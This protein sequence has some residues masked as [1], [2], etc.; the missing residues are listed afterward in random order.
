MFVMQADGVTRRAA[1]SAL[2]SLVVVS[3]ARAQPVRFRSVR[4]DVSPLRANAG[5]PTAAW[6][7]QALPGF[8]VQA[9]APYLVPGDRAGATLIARIDYVYLGPSSGGGFGPFNRSQD[10]IEGSLLVGG[11]R[12]VI[13]ART[14]VR[15]IS[16]YFPNPFDQPLRVESN[17]DRIVALARNFAYWAP[18]QLGL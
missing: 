13:A 16:S 15:A 5:D 2:A 12:G 4:V 3:V 8:L 6:V 18:G 9:F 10:T 7:Q 17:H 14:P 1:L 11:P